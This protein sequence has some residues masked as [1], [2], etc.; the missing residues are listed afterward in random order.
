MSN[1]LAY[2]LD[3]ENHKERLLEGLK[4]YPLELVGGDYDADPDNYVR[5]VIDS[6]QE[7]DL[8][9]SQ[10][11]ADRVTAEEALNLSLV[12]P[13]SKPEPKQKLGFL[14]RLFGTFHRK[15]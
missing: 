14:R 2:A 9:I 6:Q 8:L 4:E 11:K 3:L 5:V 12:W 7:L 13:K 10:L 15:K 1:R